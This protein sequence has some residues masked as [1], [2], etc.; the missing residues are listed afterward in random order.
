[1]SAGG[2]VKEFDIEKAAYEY[3]LQKADAW[4]DEHAPA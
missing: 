2:A 1:V 4:I 3:G